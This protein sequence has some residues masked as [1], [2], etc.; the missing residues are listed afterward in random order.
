LLERPT[1]RHVGAAVQAGRRLGGARLG[2]LAVAVP[3]RLQISA[4]AR[5]FWQ[6]AIPI[7]GALHVLHFKCCDLRRVQVASVSLVK[8][9]RRLMFGRLFG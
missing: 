9:V 6:R 3:Q 5:P 2:R 4:D 1:Q 8:R 7:D